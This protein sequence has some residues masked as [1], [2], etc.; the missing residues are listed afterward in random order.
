MIGWSSCR[1]S[2]VTNPVRI[3]EDTGSI[4]GLSQWVNDLAVSCGVGH[5]HGLDL[6]L[7]WLWPAAAALIRSLAWELPYALGVALKRQNTYI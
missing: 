3:H 2:A 1:G 7:L 5:R 4:P 6:A